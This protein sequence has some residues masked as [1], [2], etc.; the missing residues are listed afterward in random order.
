MTASGLDS[1][2]STS[3]ASTVPAAAASA[4]EVGED[5]NSAKHLYCV[6]AQSP[7]I[8]SHSLTCNFTSQTAT[9]LIIAKSTL[10]EVHHLTPNG[11]EAV[12]SVPLYA[13][14]G[15]FKKRFKQHYAFSS[16][17]SIAQPFA[18]SPGR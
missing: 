1:A 12:I 6:T 8:T 17:Q 4:E 5:R 10:I 18:A 16:K 11:I 2:Q 9:N 15:Q 14:I 7:T 3:N 13:R